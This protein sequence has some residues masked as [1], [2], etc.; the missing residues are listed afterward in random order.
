LL[1]RSCQYLYGRAWAAA[2]L[3]NPVVWLHV[4][5]TDSPGGMPAIGAR[6]E[7]AAQSAEQPA[8]ATEHA[9]QQLA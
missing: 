1:R 8:W 5:Q 3:Q 4:Q 2:N 9:Q 7:D 6:H